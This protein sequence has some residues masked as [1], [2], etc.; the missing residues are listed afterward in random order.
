MSRI[1][2]RYVQAFIDH[3]TGHVYY[4]FR[5]TGFPRVPLPGLP[6]SDQFMMAYRTAVAGMPMEIGA[7]R[8]KLGSISSTL[9]SYYVSTEF[10]DALAPS[11]QLIRRAILEK[12]R[13]EHGDK[14]VNLLP[15]KFLV[16]M[17]GQLKAH[18]QRNWLKAIRGLM[19]FALA[20]EMI[21]N[22]PTAGIKLAKV[23]SDGFYTWTEDDISTF[24]AKHAIGSKP[25]LAFELLLNTAQRRGDVIRMGKQHIRDGVLTVRQQKTGVTLKIP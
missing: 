7:S 11:T 18:T 3:K 8:N 17:L 10:K 6:G 13:A 15:Q 19:Q 1:K 23:K 16:L 12:F 20:R 22:D 5:R 25:R 4:Y 24:E 21:A 2:L 14:P 9:A